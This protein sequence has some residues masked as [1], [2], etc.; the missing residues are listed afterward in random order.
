MS[1]CRS[2]GIKERTSI[3]LEDIDSYK[4]HQSISSKVKMLLLTSSVT[5]AT[6]SAF[7]LADIDNVNLPWN[8]F[9]SPQSGIGSWYRS[10]AV[11]DPTNGKSW[12]AYKYFNSDTVFAVVNATSLDSSDKCD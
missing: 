4:L 5:F 2:D 6:L 11:Q 3:A 8:F 7:A 9:N 12:C 1:S 10:S